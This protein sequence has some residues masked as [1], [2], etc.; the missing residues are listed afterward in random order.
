[1]LIAISFNNPTSTLDQ[2]QLYADQVYDI[3]K[4]YPENDHVFQLNTP[5]PD[6]RRHGAEALERAQEDR[7]RPCSSACRTS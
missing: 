1:M 3:F 2:R 4:K 6:D 5:G 7:H